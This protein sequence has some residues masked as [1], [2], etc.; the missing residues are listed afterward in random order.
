MP[1]H[2]VEIN[3]QTTYFGYVYMWCDMERDMFYIG[4]HKGSIFDNYKSGSK[5]LNDSIKKRPHTFKMLVLDYYYGDD[6]HE[7]YDLETK[8]LKFYNV[9]SNDAYY[10]FKNQA[11]GGMVPFKHKGKKRAEYT[12]GWVDH[13][14]GKTAEEI[15]NNPA[16]FKERLRKQV[17]N[18]V[19]K[20]GHGWRKGIKNK[21]PYPFKG[22][23]VEERYGYR[24]LANPDK[25]FVITIYENNNKEPYDIHCLNEREFYKKVKMDY[26]NLKILK[27]FG[28][29]IVKRINPSARHDYPIG[30]M[31]KLKFVTEITK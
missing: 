8:W 25:P 26:T 20:H 4:S 5:W 19:E 24:K 1:T 27:D 10:N 23:T 29:K 22:K 21:N 12:P 3:E 30:T 14:K 11:K 17:Y 28:E 9:E 7:L 18:Y 31:L 6:R 16:V 2:G 13:R 15:Y